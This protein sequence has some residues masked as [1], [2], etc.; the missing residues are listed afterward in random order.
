[1]SLLERISSPAELRKLSIGELSELSGEIRKYIIEVVSERG[2]HLAS[3]L[4]AV[5]IAI[6]VH[7]VF[8]TPRDRIV[9][10]V[11]HQSYA[12]KII[13][14]RREA[15]K[16]MRTR[17]GISGFPNINESEY[18]PYGVGHAS[19]AI[20]AALGI[21]TA[22]D[23]AREDFFVVSI[24]GDG[25]LS[26]GLAFEGINHAGHLKKDRFVV[27]LNDNEMSI[28]RNVGALARYLTKITTKKLYR[29]LEADVWDLL[30]RIPNIGGSAR[31][32]AKRIKESI[33]NLVVPTILF[34]ELGF[35]YFGPFDGN[36]LSQ[37]IPTLKLI[38]DVPGPVL[39]HV[40]TKKGKGYCFAEEDSE[41]FHG[42]SSFYKTSG[43]A[44]N[45][46]GKPSYS[47]I[48]GN[49][50]VELARKDGKIVAVTAAMKEGTGLGSFAN[51]FP[52]R[53]FD[54]GIAEQ[55]AVTF[56]AGLA[57]QGY[58][59]FVAV[60]STFLQR[61]F[62]QIVHD[63][64]LQKLPVRF[65][66][67]RAGVVGEDGP[68]HHGAFDISYLRLIPNM[69][70]MVPRDG[71][72]LRVMLEKALEFDS[73]PIAIRFPR[74]AAPEALR[75]MLLE[76][77]E[78][79]RGELMREGDF[80]CIIALGSMVHP[81][82]EASE[83]LSKEGLDIGVVDARFAK[84][85]DCDLIEKLAGSGAPI[86]TVEENSLKGGFGEEVAKF[87]ISRNLPNKVISL[88]LPDRF[89]PHGARRELLE[90]L[91]LS[92]A[93]IAN[94]VKNLSRAREN[95]SSGGSE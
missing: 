50:L 42:V 27:I 61:A 49:S 71:E 52:D 57:M 37:L 75:K 54:V 88:G 85:I 45:N 32:L 51:E 39:L 60:Y 69:V 86:I 9:W 6:A 66:I 19:T 13:T 11:G 36:D 62:D 76:D 74:G 23:L 15:F 33:K 7:Y 68:T 46:S 21:A 1:M 43:R 67:D 93:A 56:S 87:C 84:P 94:C 70:I 81:S 14:G 17:G 80:A 31:K 29:R 89:V 92:A 12:H 41:K 53:F 22:R 91:G 24:V 90:E 10:D 3:S 5:E 95:T 78:I 25:A 55:H 65:V 72:T 44:R 77:L 47:E 38:K 4:G 40:M 82:L 8:D 48:F 16:N 83:I 73:G 59:P 18:D 64:A 30:G 34:E 35:R 20:S 26:G 58:K 63:V 79:G 28:S 2:G